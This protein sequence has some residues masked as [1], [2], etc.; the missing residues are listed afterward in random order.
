M[1]ARACVRA[2][3][4]AYV[5]FCIFFITPMTT[6]ACVCMHALRVHVRACVLACA[7]HGCAN[8]CMSARVHVWTM[9]WSMGSWILLVH[10][11]CLRPVLLGPHI[12]PV[13]HAQGE[14]RRHPTVTAAGG[15][16]ASL[17]LT[18]AIRPPVCMCACVRVRQ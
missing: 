18:L 1:P 13:C 7:C 15:A 4:H 10:R 16:A 6:R 14:S 9:V 11:V 12:V 8:P 5:N 3:M 2:R 17:A